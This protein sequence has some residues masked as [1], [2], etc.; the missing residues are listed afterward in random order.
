MNAQLIR[1]LL[2]TIFAFSVL[3]YADEALPQN[4]LE[5]QVTPPTKLQFT[6]SAPTDFSNVE[7]YKLYQ[8]FKKGVY[9][10][11][12][13]IGKTTSYTLEKVD[14]SKPNFFT[15][16]AY[17]KSGVES[18]PSNEVMVQKKPAKPKSLKVKEP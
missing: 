9:T 1:M 6:W 17:N 2:L 14:F 13:D 11:T 8:G 12:H 18:D 15:V 10:V 5:A 3:L 4:V 7:G 16:R